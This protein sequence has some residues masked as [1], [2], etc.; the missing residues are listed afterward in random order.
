MDSISKYLA[1]VAVF[2][3]FLFSWSVSAVS[4]PVNLLINPG[5]EMGNKTGW[6][7]SGGVG[8]SNALSG[9]YR[10]KIDGNPAEWRSAYQTYSVVAGKTYTFSGWLKVSN[11]T[12]GNYRFEVRWY[13][14]DG[15]QVS[16][17]KKGFGARTSNGGYA[18]SSI[19]ITAPVG[20]VTGR[21]YMQGN[22]ADGQGYFDDLSVVDN[23][24]TGTVNVQDEFNVTITDIGVQGDYYYLRTEPALSLN[25]EHSVIYSTIDKS[26]TDLTYSALLAAK[27]SGS[28]L[29]RIKYTQEANNYCYLNLVEMEDHAM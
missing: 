29:Y 13:K 25:C 11:R 17:S 12:K 21:F 16:N 18:A 28:I 6:A 9:S 27:Q 14:S 15:S 26:N 24:S 2:S 8:A 5:F 7:G 1:R 22:Q 19:E 23:S 3:T 10:Y 20:A 4:G